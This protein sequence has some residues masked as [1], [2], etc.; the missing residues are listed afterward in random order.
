MIAYAD[1]K[2]KKT[3]MCS[4]VEIVCTKEELDLLI[5]KLLDFQNKIDLYIKN[6]GKHG[7]GHLHYQDNNILWKE[8]DTDIIVYVD[9]DSLPTN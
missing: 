6:N 8:T 2:N 1:I 3:S 9:L 4:N 7:T 5:N